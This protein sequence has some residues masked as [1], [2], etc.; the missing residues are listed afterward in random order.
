M[1]EISY[2]DSND[3]V[4]RSINEKRQIWKI[5]I[6]RRDNKIGHTLCHD[7][8]LNLIVKGYVDGKTGR[9]KPRMEYISQIMKDM[10][11]RSYRDLKEPSF[12]REI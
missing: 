11:M 8:L 2:S 4:L 3:K 10:D 6:N 9:G 1:L 5:I 7:S 12:N